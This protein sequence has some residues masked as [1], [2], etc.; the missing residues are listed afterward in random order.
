M[1]TPNQYKDHGASVDAWDI[2]PP[3]T[4]WAP[5]GRSGIEVV[6]RYPG[7]PVFACW[8]YLGCACA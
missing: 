3:T 6:N 2:E 1:S 5:V 4:P 7:G 8:R